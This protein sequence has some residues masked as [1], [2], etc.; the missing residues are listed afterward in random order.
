LVWKKGFKTL[1][2]PLHFFEK[3]FQAIFEKKYYFG[4]PYFLNIVAGCLAIKHRK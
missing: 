2:E 4:Q 1:K 3:V